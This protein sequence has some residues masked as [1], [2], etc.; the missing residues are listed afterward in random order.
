MFKLPHEANYHRCAL[1]P[2]AFIPF[3]T[4]PAVPF[5]AV[6]F[7]AWTGVVEEVVA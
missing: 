3:K 7:E 5:T 2:R 1:N 6:A 4:D